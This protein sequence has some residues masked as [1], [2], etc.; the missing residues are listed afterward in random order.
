MTGTSL[1]GEDPN[2]IE[3]AFKNKYGWQYRAVGLTSGLRKK[4]IGDPTCFRFV[5]APG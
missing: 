5:A 4:K 1:N 3:A 2:Q